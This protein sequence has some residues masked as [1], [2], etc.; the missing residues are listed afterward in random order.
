MYFI[1]FYFFLSVLLYCA[2]QFTNSIVAAVTADV[3]EYL[4]HMY[5]S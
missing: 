1:L 3:V 2:A 4:C 5:V